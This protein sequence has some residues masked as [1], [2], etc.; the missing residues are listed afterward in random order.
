MSWHN[1]IDKTIKDHLKKLILEVQEQR[2]KNKII[3]PKDDEIFR[4]FKA[5]SFETIKVVILGQ[6]PYHGYNQANGLA[7][8]VAKGIPLPPSLKNI[9]REIDRDLNIKNGANG[10]LSY[11]AEQGVLLLNSVLT[12]EAYKAHSHADLGWQIFTDYILTE[13]SKRK[14]HIIF[15]L[16]GTVA[17]NSVKFIDINKHFV[18]KTSHPSPLSAHRGFLGCG[19]FSLAN[20]LL[21]K[22]KGC[23]IDWR[24]D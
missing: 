4:A 22:Y 9:Y 12:V 18:L 10:D 19:H 14:R 7:F 21:L 1:L 17:Q 5:C 15:M 6:D 11:W 13:I 23:T 3:F 20:Q 24:I 8:S 16:W 2:K